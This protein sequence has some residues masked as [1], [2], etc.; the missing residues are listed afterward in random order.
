MRAPPATNTRF[1]ACVELHGRSL[2]RVVIGVSLTRPG[3]PWKV[4]VTHGGTARFFGGYCTGRVAAGCC[5]LFSVVLVLWILMLWFFE[6]PCLT[7]SCCVVFR[8][9]FLLSI[10]FLAATA[11][12][13]LGFASESVFIHERMT[14]PTIEDHFTRP[15]PHSL[16]SCADSLSTWSLS[17]SK[18]VEADTHPRSNP[19]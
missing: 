3:G 17:C 4:L 8:H 19:T 1:S 5:S 14:F 18:S 9:S 16:H 2:R 11:V 7:S 13:K 6:G 12:E 10:F 15:T